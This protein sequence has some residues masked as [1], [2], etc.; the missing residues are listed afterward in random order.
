M[1]I[2]PVLS[3]NKPINLSNVIWQQTMLILS[4][5]LCQQTAVWCCQQPVVWYCQQAVVWWWYC[6]LLSVNRHTGPFTD[7]HAVTVI[8]THTHARTH[9][10]M[11][12]RTHV[13]THTHCRTLTSTFISECKGKLCANGG[14]LNVDT[15][16]CMCA[17]G[18][19]GGKC[20][21]REYMY[22][23]HCLPVCHRLSP[24]LLVDCWW[25]HLLLTLSSCLSQT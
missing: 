4:P 9:A 19:R 11:H 22:F 24:T 18:W 25:V 14:T 7:A 13:R 3:V 2:C 12:V 5:A 10:R 23:W 21:A 8:H 16:R 6:P 15:C 1:L 17:Y 20:T